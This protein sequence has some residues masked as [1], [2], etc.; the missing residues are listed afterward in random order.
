M[1][2]QQLRGFEQSSQF[3]ARLPLVKTARHPR[4]NTENFQTFNHFKYLFFICHIS[5]YSFAALMK[6]FWVVEQQFIYSD[7]WSST[8]LLILDPDSWI[9]SLILIHS[10]FWSLILILDP[11][12]WSWCLILVQCSLEQFLPPH[13]KVDAH[14]GL[15]VGTEFT[16]IQKTKDLKAILSSSREFFNKMAFNQSCCS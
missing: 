12:P 2:E 5:F 13:V 14:L 10:W 9:R 7:L 3:H 11:G 1:W 15:S 16:V 8:L 4:N 6:S